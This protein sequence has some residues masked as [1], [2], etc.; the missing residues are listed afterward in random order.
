MNIFYSKNLLA[1]IKKDIKSF[2]F[3]I[4]KKRI[5]KI[6]KSENLISSELE[7]N[8]EFHET[9]EQFQGIIIDNK[10]LIYFTPKLD[11]NNK[12]KSRNTYIAQNFKPC[13]FLSKI[14]NL[15][16]HVTLN[17]Y[18]YDLDISNNIPESI[19]FDLKIL[20]TLK[21]SI[22]SKF[23]ELKRFDSIDEF[24]NKKRKISNKNMGNNGTYIYRE[25]Q[26]IFIYGKT[27]GAN[28]CKTFIESL[29]I[30]KLNYQKLNVYFIPLNDKYNNKTT[31]ELKSV[32]IEIINNNFH[33]P[34][35]NQIHPIE[36]KQKIDRNQLEF[37]KNIIN[38]YEKYINIDQ[39][40][41]CEY[42]VA[43]NLIS[44]HIHRVS[45]I[46]KDF[47]NR[48]ISKEEAQIS[49]VSGENGF[50]LCPNHD[51]E[52]EKGM[53]YFDLKNM[54]FRVNQ[55]YKKEILINAL[56]NKK[57]FDNKQIKTIEFENYIIKHLNRIF[58]K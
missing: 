30:A 15:N 23:G 11:I 29:I 18:D 35:N 1:S 4:F 8:I 6:I 38:K 13:Y 33:L 42:N 31:Q 39:C 36:Q 21:I 20:K 12:F 9:K 58:H 16:I 2:D 25:Y 10:I 53:I 41:A 48:I 56:K 7:E 40:F 55:K 22:S 50:R 19:K 47:E 46:N 17:P 37:L 34:S 5:I 14:K 28:G 52:F 27:D 54:K 43:E 24:I 26:G 44:A 3:E 49:I 57:E 45:D 32:G 51:K